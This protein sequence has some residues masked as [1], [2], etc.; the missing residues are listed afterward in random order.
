[1]ANS[2][3]DIPYPTPADRK[4]LEKIVKANWNAKVQVPLAQ[5][6]ESAADH[7]SNVKGW[8]FDRYVAMELLS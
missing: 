3:T 1:M 4:D 8:I 2:S 5:T 7:L 6:S